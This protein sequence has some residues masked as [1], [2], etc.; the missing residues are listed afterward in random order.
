MTSILKV[1]DWKENKAPAFVFV[2]KK[3]DGTQVVSRLKDGIFFTRFEFFRYN[4]E[5]ADIQMFSGN[6]THVHLRI[7]YEDKKYKRSIIC[8]INKL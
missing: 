1:K 6:M 8:H 3:T 5:L 2:H 7:Y 4:G